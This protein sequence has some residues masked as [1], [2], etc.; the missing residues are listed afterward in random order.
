MYSK[1]IETYKKKL[2]LTKRQREV[3]VGTLLGDGHLE[4]QQK[5]KVPRLLIE[6]SIKQKDFVDW[7]Y[8]ELKSLVRTPPKIK[9][10]A[11]NSKVY[12]KYWFRTLSLSSFRFYH[13]Q[14]YQENKKVVPKLVHKWLTPLAL[15][16]WF[17]DDGSIKSKYHKARIINT[18]RFKKSDVE[19]LISVLSEKYGVSAKLRKQKEGYQIYLLSETI[20]RFVEIVKPYIIPSMMYKLRGLS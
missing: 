10:R 4:W 13:H 5:G 20:N 19:R 11:V 3:I 14:F 9:E 18:Q 15:A 1:Q 7:K 17:M 2:R 16:I 12:Q 8:K 6:H